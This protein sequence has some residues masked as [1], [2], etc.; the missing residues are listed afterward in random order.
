MTADTHLTLHDEELPPEDE[1]IV[2]PMSFGQQRMW[3]LDQFQRG[4]D[5]SGSPFY[6]IPSAIRL[7]GK[8]DALTEQNAALLAALQVTEAPQVSTEAAPE[9]PARR[10][11]KPAE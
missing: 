5:G 8:L 3:F 9:K 6:N 10:P 11:R 4:P 1:L 2:F 7:T